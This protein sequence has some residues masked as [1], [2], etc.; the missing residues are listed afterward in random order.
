V[1]EYG[2]VVVNDGA[3]E[4]HTIADDNGQTSGS[5]PNAAT[6]DGSGPPALRLVFVNPD[7]TPISLTVQFIGTDG[8][9]EVFDSHDT[10]GLTSG[11]LLASLTATTWR[12]LS[13]RDGAVIVTST[14]GVWV[15][16]EQARSCH[17]NV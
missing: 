10:S 12:S 11:P 14:A 8:A 6:E 2:A 1:R 13:D 4:I 5:E 15:W 3:G 9:V 7:G 16:C 17:Y